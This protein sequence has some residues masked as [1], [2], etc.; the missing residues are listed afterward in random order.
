M[1]AGGVGGGWNK[2]LMSVL[3]LQFI[4]G[5]PSSLSSF[6]FSLCLFD[7]EFER[8]LVVLKKYRGKYVYPIFDYKSKSY[9]LI[10]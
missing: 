3:L 2:K 6:G 1:V 4:A 5:L 10:F 8:F 7:T 9:S